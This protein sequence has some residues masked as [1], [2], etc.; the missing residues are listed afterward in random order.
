MITLPLNTRGA[1]VIVYDILWSMIVSC[2]QTVLPVAA[3]SAT[4]RPS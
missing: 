2:S 4:S 1:P 3:S